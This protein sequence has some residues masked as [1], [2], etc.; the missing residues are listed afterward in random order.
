[1][2][3]QDLE[4]LPFS[5]FFSQQGHVYAAN[6]LAGI[7]FATSNDWDVAASYAWRCH[8][9]G[10]SQLIQRLY[11]AQ[12]EEESYEIL[13]LQE[14]YV[15][16]QESLRY[17]DEMVAEVLNH[18]DWLPL[19]HRCQRVYLDSCGNARAATL[20]WM[21]SRLLPRDVACII[22]CLVWASRKDPSTW[23]V[24]LPPGAP[25]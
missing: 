13:R 2:T 19:L 8:Y 9:L 12:D 4:T 14:M 16:G 3:R 7:L 22:G 5:S 6:R 23:G 21:A 10:Y 25:Q 18:A 11:L 24:E 15:Y 20:T 1:M 17:T